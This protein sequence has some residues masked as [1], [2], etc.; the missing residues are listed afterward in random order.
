MNKTAL[1]LLLVTLL[2]ACKKKKNLTVDDVLTDY[3][4]KLNSI[5]KISY[6]MQKI[7]T[8]SSGTIWNKKGKALLEKNKND[9]IFGFSYYAINLKHNSA[10]IYNK[11][12]HFGIENDTKEFEQEQAG[13]Y[14]LGSPGGQMVYK[15]IFNFDEEAISKDLEVTE[16][17]YKITYHLADNKQYNIVSR[18]KVIEIDKETNLLRRVHTYHFSEIANHKQTSTYIFSDV[19]TNE[20]I[21]KT[22]EEQ[23]AVLADYK[24]ILPE[25]IIPNKLLGT[26]LPKINLQNLISKKVESLQT[27]KVILIDFWEVWCGYCIQSFPKVDELAKKYKDLKVIGIVTENEEQAVRLVEKKDVTFTNLLGTKELLNTFSVNSFPRYFLIDKNGIIQKEY[28]GFSKDIEKDI[29]K[30]I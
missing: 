13:L 29:K 21:Q 18:K 30:M 22:V 27:E 8:F 10:S 1:F 28:H 11:Y 16:D 9:T 3:K 17:T 25:E 5:E 19:K 7:D 20:T 23:L 15:D 6:N 24:Q 14:V 2:S 12:N 4:N 26:H